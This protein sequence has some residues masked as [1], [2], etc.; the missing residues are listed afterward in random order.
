MATAEALG[1]A[2]AALLGYAA[3]F[4]ELKRQ[5][6]RRVFVPG[7]LPCPDIRGQG[8]NLGHDGV[9]GGACGKLGASALGYF[10]WRTLGLPAPRDAA[11]ECLWYLVSGSH[12]ANPKAALL[13][14]DTEGLIDIYDAK[15]RLLA[16]GALAVLF[17][18][19]APLPG[20]AREDSPGA[21]CRQ[22]HDP[23]QFLESLPNGIA[24]PFERTAV[25]LPAAGSDQAAWLGR[26]AL[27][28]TAKRRP[29]FAAAPF[30]AGWASRPAADAEAS[31]GVAQR[32]AACLMRFAAANGQGRL[33]WAAPLAVKADAKHEAFHAFR[34]ADKK[35]ELSG[36]PPFS[37]GYSQQ[38]LG[39]D[40][41]ELPQ[42]TRK[43][44]A[45]AAC[46][47]L[48][49]DAC[50]EFRPAAGNVR[51]AGDRANKESPDGW[52]DKWKDRFFYVVAPG[53]A[54]GGQ[55]PAATAADCQ[56]GNG[57][58][59]WLGK[60]PCAAAVIYAGD[61]LTGQRRGTLAEKQEAANYLEGE[62]LNAV[63]GQGLVLGSGEAGNDRIVCIAPAEAEGGALSMLSF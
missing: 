43:D 40:L 46:R 16:R 8:A 27:W 38:A 32:L 17:A 30:D 1:E 50:P 56:P 62:N 31:P 59:L 48:R 18:P 60:Q 57:Q 15:G 47:L 7:H 58:C 49:I 28:R 33:P 41:G 4:P 14:P 10:P 54:P 21:F 6:G 26:D 29:G 45:N 25:R 23:A 55:G 61:A 24:P 19:G 39:A 9:E 12:K 42:C 2:Q 52:W 3:A 63:L 34:Q 44:Y 20:Q 37:V 36:R 11:G 51:E 35:D 53:F 5:S 13:N 22:D